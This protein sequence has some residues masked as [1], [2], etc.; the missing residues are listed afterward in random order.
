MIFTN[1]NL[2]IQGI[3]K[4]RATI[5]KKINLS[6]TALFCF[7]KK[8]QSAEHAIGVTYKKNLKIVC[9]HDIIL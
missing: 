9:E 5:G 4:V 6:K 1:I 7:G 3:V 2:Q 8:A